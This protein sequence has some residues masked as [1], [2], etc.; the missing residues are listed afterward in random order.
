[1]ISTSDIYTNDLLPDGVLVGKD[2]C[3]RVV[4]CLEMNP[5][6][7]LIWQ[8]P[9]RDTVEDIAEWHVSPTH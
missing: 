5:V 9:Y 1:M 4:V 6:Y 8:D 2:A 3:G 7:N